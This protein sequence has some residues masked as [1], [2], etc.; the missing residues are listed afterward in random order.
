MKGE[1][2]EKS[3]KRKKKIKKKQN[4]K[5]RYGKDV[6]IRDCQ[7][8]YILVIILLIRFFFVI[9]FLSR[10]IVG[11]HHRHVCWDPNDA[12]RRWTRGG[13]SA[14]SFILSEA[15][16]AAEPAEEDPS[17]G[18]VPPKEAER[19]RP[20]AEEVDCLPSWAA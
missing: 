18:A 9:F 3:G 2:K 8:I 16:A 13:R 7:Y 5:C 6:E 11:L 4:H 20:W 17:E 19:D 14:G 15:A 10:L 1:K 12:I